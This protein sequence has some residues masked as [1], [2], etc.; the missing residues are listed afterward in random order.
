M[1][2]DQG[3]WVDCVSP[4]LRR[5]RRWEQTPRG[6]GSAPAVSGVG[7]G[8]CARWGQKP[9]SRGSA[10][11]GGGGW[12]VVGLGWCG[13]AGLDSAHSVTHP[14][15]PQ[16]E[17]L[18]LPAGAFQPKTRTHLITATHAHAHGHRH[19]HPH[20]HP[21][22]NPTPPKLT[23][24]HTCTHTWLAAICMHTVSVTRCISPLS[25]ARNSGCA[26]SAARTRSSAAPRAATSEGCAWCARTGAHTSSSRCA[27]FEWWGGR[28]RRV[29]M[30]AGWVC[31]NRDVQ[32]WG[33]QWRGAPGA[34]GQAHT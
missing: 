33:A 28:G 25:P 19:A 4:S 34:P 15:H 2:E 1:R 22:L 5:Q 23:P 16:T 20:P 7:W 24:S 32:V 3:G 29:R 11:A 10:A 14:L 13:R 26:A 30:C 31:R 18:L 17:S 9:C 27:C 6:R 8:E 21:R 12:G